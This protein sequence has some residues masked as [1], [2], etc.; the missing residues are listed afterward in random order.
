MG[1]EDNANLKKHF[2]ISKAAKKIGVTRQTMHNWIKKG[3]A[4]P[5][6]IIGGRKY[7]SEQDI[8]NIFSKDEE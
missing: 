6:V 1:K 8:N 7:F 5:S 2:N 3:I 4:L